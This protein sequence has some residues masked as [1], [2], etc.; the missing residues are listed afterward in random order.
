ME[1]R[2]VRGAVEIAN[3]MDERFRSR[4]TEVRTKL[5]DVMK[6]IAFVIMHILRFL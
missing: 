4:L 1:V 5:D 3:S 6:G 2:P